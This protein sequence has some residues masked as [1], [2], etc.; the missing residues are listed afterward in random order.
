ML[1]QKNRFGFTIVRALICLT[2][3]VVIASCKKTEALIEESS[4]VDIHI[5]DLNNG[6]EITGEP[7]KNSEAI[8]FDL[9]AGKEVAV[10]DSWDIA[11]LGMANTTISANTKAGTWLQIA[12][13]DYDQVN[14]RPSLNYELAAIGNGSTNPNGWFSYDTNTH[15]VSPIKAKTVFVKTETGIYKL[16]MISIYKGAPQYPSSTDKAPFLSFRYARLIN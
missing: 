4:P 6:E 12:N 10:L 15:L 14:K 9:S 13:V 2:I 8:Y 3:I 7:S 1:T 16:A 5:S 11:F